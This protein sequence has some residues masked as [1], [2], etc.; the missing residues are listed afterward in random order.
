MRTSYRTPACLYNMAKLTQTPTADVQRTPTVT[1][2]TDEYIQLAEQL[3]TVMIKATSH[4]FSWLNIA[5]RDG[6]TQFGKAR[7]RYEGRVLDGIVLKVHT[8][9]TR[10]K[11]SFE[12]WQD[13][14][15]ATANPTDFILEAAQ[16]GQNADVADIA[17]LSHPECISPDP[18]R[19]V[20]ASDALG[21]QQEN[22]GNVS[23][24]SDNP[25]SDRTAGPTIHL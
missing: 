20:V 24:I 15:A 19:Q 17:D 8:D 22:V 3:D 1:E 9:N 11:F 2:V 6:Q 4:L 12:V 14:P 7:R 18:K 21:N 5:E 13:D 23:D 10:P 25:G 16:P